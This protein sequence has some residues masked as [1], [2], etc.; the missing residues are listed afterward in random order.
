M[1]YRRW[2]LTGSLDIAPTF[3][4]DLCAVAGCI[5][6][7]EIK[8]FCRPHYSRFRTTGD[9]GD[10]TFPAKA[11]PVIDGTKKCFTCG[12]VKPVSDFNKHPQG[13]GGVGSNCRLCL[14]V[15]SR[16][17]F[18]K[19]PEY[20]SEWNTNNAERKLAD[21]HRRRAIKM[22]VDADLIDRRAVFERDNNACQLC[23][24]PMDMSKKTP[25]PLAPTI[26][27]I[28]PISR[29]GTHTMDNIQSA[30]F[31]CNI[32]KGNRDAPLTRPLAA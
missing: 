16:E 1:H 4:R 6:G 3:P 11:A 12:E 26:D 17:W 19:N 18:A 9:A 13:T 24:D 10:A 14:S 29:G 32:S 8:S 28:V 31:H 7:S 23:G 20:R 5:T 25:H 2:R 22:D 30:H 21:V 15:K 27:H